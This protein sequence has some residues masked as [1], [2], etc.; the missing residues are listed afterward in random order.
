MAPRVFR[1]ASD[2]PEPSITDLDGEFEMTEKKPRHRSWKKLSCGAFSSPSSW[3]LFPDEN[4]ATEEEKTVM[5]KITFR[6]LPFLCFLYFLCFLDRSNV[7]NAHDSMGIDLGL[8]DTDYSNAVGIFFAGYILFEVP[9]NLMLKRVTPHR[10]ISRI[11]VSWGIVC[12][13][14]AGITSLEG[15]MISRFLLGVMEA[16]FYPGIIFYLT[17]WYPSRER[18]SII[19]I[20]FISSTLSGFL[21]G[22]FSYLIL[23]LDGV[24][25]LEG[26]R[27]L[28]LLE[29][30]PTVAA[31]ISV[32]FYLPDSPD[33]CPWL[34]P[35]ERS[36]VMQR[37]HDGSA[38]H[39]L[40]HSIS[41]TEIITTLTN[42]K[43]WVIAFI[44]LCILIPAYGVTFFLP[45]MLNAFGHTGVLANLLSSPIYLCSLVVAL[46]VSYQSDQR[47]HDRPFHIALIFALAAV[48][49][50][51]L[52]GALV[53]GSAVLQ[54]LSIMV[55]T[56]FTWALVAPL[57]AWITDS[58]KSTTASATGIALVVSVGNAGGYLGPTV[59]S[60]LGYVSGMVA[61]GFVMLVGAVTTV[62]ARWIYESVLPQTASVVRRPSLK[63]QRSLLMKQRLP[64]PD[65]EA[66]TG[67]VIEH[68]DP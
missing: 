37:V 56:S 50:F 10:W 33:T 67:V 8:S 57:N 49:Y 39:S 23:Q 30:I 12:C 21:G 52:V 42:N 36:M 18:A 2:A 45:A 15:L 44:Y 11:M 26:W 13:C 41:K 61:M 63:G 47:R 40:D 22:I 1:L 66:F 35:T 24:G 14:M 65:L 31:G 48:S 9:S 43:V 32:W 20:F 17:F 27:W 4:Y 60:N 59:L 3:T 62:A 68:E 7:A 54:Y 55:A 19:A 51:C 64:D 16:G 28:F 29:G 58:L 38:A 46:Y 5:R 6:L 34:S 25:G 53:S